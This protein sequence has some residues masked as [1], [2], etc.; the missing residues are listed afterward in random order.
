MYIETEREKGEPAR[1]CMCVLR[2]FVIRIPNMGCLALRKLEV[3]RGLSRMP[4]APLRRKCHV[5]WTGSQPPAMFIEFSGL[6][7]VHIAP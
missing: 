7:L 5:Q 6:V 2:M 1:V 3:P 4:A